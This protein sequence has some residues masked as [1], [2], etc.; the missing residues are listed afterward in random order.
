MGT[1]ALCL[2]SDFL[3][4]L[5]NPGIPVA[6]SPNV[7]LD[8]YLSYGHDDEKA[9]ALNS[10]IVNNI[11]RDLPDKIG[12]SEYGFVFSGQGKYENIQRVMNFIMENKQKFIDYK[13]GSG[14]KPFEKYF[15]GNNASNPIQAMVD[16]QMFGLDCIGFVGR[17][18]E[19]AGLIRSYIRKVP[20]QYI[21]MGPFK[22][23]NSI[24]EIDALCALVWSDGSHI[25]I[26]N[27]G[28]FPMDTYVCVQIC[29]STAGGP[30]LN[31]WTVIRS[32]SDSGDLGALFKVTIEQPRIRFKCDTVYIGQIPGV[33]PPLP[34]LST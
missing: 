3:D 19:Y 18:L 25:A 9:Q 32:T 13:D 16:D 1:G 2:P 4:R 30:Q 12:R 20:K 15:T 10:A 33:R 14:K 7:K 11:G 21:T 28:I 17:Y 31:R 29:Q 23:I 27:M 26:I 24:K 22:A 5:L 34:P 8:S 6:S